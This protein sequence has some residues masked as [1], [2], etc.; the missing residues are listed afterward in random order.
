LRARNSPFPPIPPVGHVTQMRAANP[1]FAGVFVEGPDDVEMWRR[2]LNAVPLPCSGGPGVRR[3]LEDIRQAGI[4]GCLGVVDADFARLGG[5]QVEDPDIIVSSTHDH[6]CDLVC[7]AA[8]DNLIMSIPGAEPRLL[9]LAR[10]HSHLRDAIRERALQFGLVRWLFYVESAEFPAHL[11][12]GNDSLFDRSSWTLNRGA[13]FAAAAAALGTDRPELERRM[14]ALCVPVGREWEVCNGH[15]VVS[16]LRL[17]FSTIECAAERCRSE[18]SV[19]WALRSALD[20]EHL[21]VFS[22][23]QQLLAWESR[24]R[25][26]IAKRQAGVGMVALE[27][28]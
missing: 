3:A 8:L 15:D 17:A 10:P 7:S 6:E 4:M 12:P 5:V 24:N 1:M 18:K 13:L 26:Y 14:D 16:L 27:G 20:S 23:W 25:P 22:L 2:W 9:A 19:A 28:A 11:C 21:A